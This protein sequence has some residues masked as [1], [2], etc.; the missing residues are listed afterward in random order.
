LRVL[1]IFRSCY[2]GLNVIVLR[3]HYKIMMHPLHTS[4]SWTWT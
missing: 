2:S 3:K 1:L 4:E